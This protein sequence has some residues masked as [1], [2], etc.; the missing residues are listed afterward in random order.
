MSSSTVTVIYLRL[1]KYKCVLIMSSSTVI[2]GVFF[3][4]CHLLDYFSR[5]LTTRMLFV[6]GRSQFFLIRLVSKL[7]L[8]DARSYSNRILKQCIVM[9]LR[10]FPIN[11]QYVILIT[12]IENAITFATLNIGPF[13]FYK[14]I[15]NSCNHQKTKFV[16]CFQFYCMELLA[17][18]CDVIII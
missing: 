10:C 6:Y 2:R 12:S 1:C 5:G 17:L 11:L 8:S 15:C 14:Y 18:L 16:E 13:P 4:S 7:L 3:N 9:T